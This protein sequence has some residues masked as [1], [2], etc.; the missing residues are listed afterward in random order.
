VRA[1]AASLEGAKDEA[2]ALAR[3]SSSFL[4][5]IMDGACRVLTYCGGDGWPWSEAA[6]FRTICCTTCR[7]TPGIWRRAAALSGSE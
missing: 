2:K 6:G 4:R 7:I 5:E 3:G 1:V